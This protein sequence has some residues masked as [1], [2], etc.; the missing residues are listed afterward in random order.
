MPQIFHRCPNSRC[1]TSYEGTAVFECASG[2]QFCGRCQRLDVRPLVHRCPYCDE[3][4][5]K[6]GA[7][8]PQAGDGSDSDDSGSDDEWNGDS[9]SA[10]GYPD[11][12]PPLEPATLS[13]VVLETGMFALIGVCIG[14]VVWAF[15]E[16][17]AGLGYRDGSVQF[18]PALLGSLSTVGFLCVACLFSQSGHTKPTTSVSL[19]RWG[20]C[21]VVCLIACTGQFS[22]SSAMERANHVDAE[23]PVQMP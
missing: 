9:V 14:G 8:R 6:I 7:I 13:S 3:A 5:E 16:Y 20:I 22:C 11:A 12:D 18:V 19:A 23:T 15:T 10:S 17:V 2:H 4:T 21:A 1:P